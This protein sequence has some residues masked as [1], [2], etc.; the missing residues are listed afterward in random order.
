MGLMIFAMMF[1]IGSL[2][3]KCQ[4]TVRLNDSMAYVIVQKDK[5]RVIVDTVLFWESKSRRGY[6]KKQDMVKSVQDDLDTMRMYLKRMKDGIRELEK[7]R[8]KK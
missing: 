1:V 4:D 8:N 7:T 2:V 5:R 6:D 3:V